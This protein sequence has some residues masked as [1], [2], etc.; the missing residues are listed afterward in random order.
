MWIYFCYLCFFKAE[1]LRL[2]CNRKKK[3]R[4][5]PA[6]ED[7]QSSSDEDSSSGSEH[8]DSSGSSISTSVDSLQSLAASQISQVSTQLPSDHPPQ[9]QANERMKLLLQ[10][11]K[12]LKIQAATPEPCPTPLKLFPSMATKAEHAIPPN[13]AAI[14]A[15][16]LVDLKADKKATV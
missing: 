16:R 3:K 9:L 15:R 7:Q 2:R 13:I 6:G 1:Q 4:S 5:K 10:S 11:F 14:F 8:E 12:G